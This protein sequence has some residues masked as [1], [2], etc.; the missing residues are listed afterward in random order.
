MLN[1]NVIPLLAP[2]QGGVA[3]SSK[4]I[5]RSH[6]SRRSR[7]GFPFGFIGK[8][9]RPRDKRMLRD[10]FLMARP[11]LLRQGGESFAQPRKMSK[12]QSRA[13]ARAR[14]ISFFADHFRQQTTVMQ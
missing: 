2:P 7:G 13:L 5:W 14:F 3:A 4:K 8:P 9:P 10:I 6:R 1:K 12:L 11:P